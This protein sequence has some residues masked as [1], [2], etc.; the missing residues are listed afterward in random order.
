MKWMFKW[1]L[2]VAFQRN[3]QKILERPRKSF[4]REMFTAFFSGY[5]G[6]EASEEGKGVTASL[7]LSSTF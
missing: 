7:H 1:N 4:F 2:G 5:S 6:L 3:E